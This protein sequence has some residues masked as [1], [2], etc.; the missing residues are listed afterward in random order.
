MT[1]K[2]LLA[3]ALIALLAVPAGAQQAPQ[4]TP[5]RIRGTVEKLD[6]QA[7]TVKPREGQQVTVTL[8]PNVTIGYLVTD[9]LP[10]RVRKRAVARNRQ[11]PFECVGARSI[12]KMTPCT[13]RRNFS[14]IVA[15]EGSKAD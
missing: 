3:G 1:T 15:Q 7:L 5:T 8:A 13:A 2:L 14:G 9:H 6:G 12:V 11:A 10:L 4:G